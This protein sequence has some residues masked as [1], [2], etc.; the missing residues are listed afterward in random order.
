M[1]KRSTLPIRE[2]ISMKRCLAIFAVALTAGLMSACEDNMPRNTGPTRPLDPSPTLEVNE[3]T[4]SGPVVTNGAVAANGR[5]FGNVT[6]AASSAALVITVSNPGTSDLNLGVPTVIGTNPGDFTLN[7][8][9]FVGTVTPGTSTTFSITFTPTA[10]GARSARVTFTHDVVQ[11][12][13]PFL[14]NLSG[15]G[16]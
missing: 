2:T 3:V 1:E 8:T 6:V 16:T 15:T 11:T 13:S 14:F 7:T 9:G 4:S 12:F 10:A 5:A